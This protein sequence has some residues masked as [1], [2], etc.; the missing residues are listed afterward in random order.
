MNRYSIVTVV[1]VSFST[2]L[3][4]F[5]QSNEPDANRSQTVIRV[6]SRA[7]LVD[8]IVTNSSGKPVTGLPKD[9]FP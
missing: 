4:L 1:L 8:V 9:A 2:V 7:V 5:G 6:E 3:S